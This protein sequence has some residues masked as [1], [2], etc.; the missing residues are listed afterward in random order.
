M[1][2]PRDPDIDPAF[3]ELARLEKQLAQLERG[4]AES[5]AYSDGTRV[6]VRIGKQDDG[7]RGFR[8]WN[9]AGALIHDYTT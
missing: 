1:P 6:R 5:Y 8:V 4:T 7:T 2:N 9:A 3:Y